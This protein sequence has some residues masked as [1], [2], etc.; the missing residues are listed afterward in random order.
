MA[1]WTVKLSQ[2]F[3]D[4]R[5]DERPTALAPFGVDATGSDD[6]KAKARSYLSKAG[7]KVRSISVCVPATTRVLSA[8]VMVKRGT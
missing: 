8:V 5:P 1:T 6:A 3:E 7:K 2:V 4:Q